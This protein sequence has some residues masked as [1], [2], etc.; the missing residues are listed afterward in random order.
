MQALAE[1][2]PEWPYDIAFDSVFE[3]SVDSARNCILRI[4]LRIFYKQINPAEI[5]APMMRGI[6]AYMG[7]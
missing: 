1:E 6:A 5:T 7:V 4:V 3:R 2:I